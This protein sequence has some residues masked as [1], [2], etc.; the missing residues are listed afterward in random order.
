M[1]PKLWAALGAV[2]AVLLILVA[3]EWYVEA[4]RDEAYDAGR[5]EERAEWL[6]RE[7]EELAAANLEIERLTREARTREQQGAAAIAALAGL[8]QE[9]MDHVRATHDAFLDDL[10]SGRV[11]FYVPGTQAACSDR[12]SE[13]PAAAG[14]GDGEA[15]AELPP[16]V[17]GFLHRLA[18][19]AD[20]IVLQLALAQ[21]V[22]EEDR[23]ICR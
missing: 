13:T 11:R 9:E 4:Q 22:I 5:T 3:F 2:A 8:H 14:R 10:A 21:G 6:K 19:E 7:S 12:G 20:E 23:R 15:R 17:A 16:A 18:S 1:S